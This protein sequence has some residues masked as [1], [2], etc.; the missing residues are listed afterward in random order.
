M[1]ASN[2][3]YF[4]K[5]RINKYIAALIILFVGIIPISSFAFLFYILYSRFETSAF[6]KE[7]TKFYLSSFV[8]F[9]LSFFVI[10]LFLSLKLEFGVNSKG[11]VFRFFPFHRKFRFI[12][13]S[14]IKNYTIRK[15]NPIFEYGG[16]G[17]RYSVKRN[18]VAYIIS[19]KY[20]LQLE[21][22]SN[23]KLLIGVKS[24]RQVLE[25]LKMFSPEKY[26]EN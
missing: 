22:V 16:W 13:F 19:G 20:G 14:E 23:K 18:G 25:F 4:E 26:V 6:T 21:L 3:E 17:I 2:T 15:Y 11:I 24:P 10:Y 5:Q 1:D 7:I 9:L 12:P 8:V